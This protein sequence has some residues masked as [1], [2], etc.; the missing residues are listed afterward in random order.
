MYTYRH[1]K[2]G[3]VGQSST[4]AHYNDYYPDVYCN[5]E[6]RISKTFVSG[7]PTNPNIS[8]NQRISNVI[9]S[10]I[11]GKVQYGYLGQPAKLNYL[12]RGEG[13]PGGGGKPPSNF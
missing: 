5:C 9:K 7:Q 6:Q 10:T 12:G 1:F 8:N 2:P 4:N 3:A 13:Q 11:G